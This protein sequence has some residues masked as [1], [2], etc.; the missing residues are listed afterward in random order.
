[1]TLSADTQR[2]VERM[3]RQQKRSASRVLESLVEK[4][5]GAE[6]AERKKLSD[7]VE[8]L[9]ATKDRDEQKRIGDE[10]GRL[11]FGS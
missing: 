4:G 11:V 9:R 2:R 5:L 6:E 10:L 1:M 8:R 3:A 7:L